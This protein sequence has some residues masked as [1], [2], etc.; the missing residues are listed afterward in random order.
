MFYT[1][2]SIRTCSRET[3]KKS[4]L[5][6]KPL[7]SRENRIELLRQL[8]GSVQKLDIEK[9]KDLHIE[10]ITGI[11][12]LDR[13]AEI[14][15]NAYNSE[16]WNDNWTKEKALEKL[17]CF[18]QSPKFHGWTAA[19][20]DE[21]LGCCVG[22]IEPYYSGDYF[23]LKEMFVYHKFQKQ[24]VGAQLLETIKSYLDTIDIQTIILFTSKDFFPFDFYLKSGFGEMEGM[25]M[26][27]FGP[28][29]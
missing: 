3:V 21:L 18:Y 1:D 20:G 5:R 15:V 27:H 2:K 14:L 22:N 9:M 23:Y 24:G 16:P 13:C 12:Q 10:K 29:E 26:L 25:R 4:E 28:T 7:K 19:R 8:S 17:T 6:E 11:D